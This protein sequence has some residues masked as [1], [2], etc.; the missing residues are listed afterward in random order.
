MDAAAQSSGHDIV[1]IRASARIESEHDYQMGLARWGKKCEDAVEESTNDYIFSMIVIVACEHE[2]TVIV[3]RLQRIPF[4]NEPGRKLFCYDSLC[5]EPVDWSAI[6]RLKRSIYGG[7]KVSMRLTNAGEENEDTL[8][9]LKNVYLAFATQRASDNLCEDITAC[10]VPGRQGDNPTNEVLNTAWKSLK[11]L[12][13]RHV[14]PKIGNIRVSQEDMLHHMYT[15]GHWNPSPEHHVL[16]TYQANPSDNSGRKRMRHL[17]DNTRCGDTFFNEWPVPMYQPSQMPRVS[18]DE[19][20]KMFAAETAVD[21]GAE[22]GAGTAMIQDLGD[23]VIP[24][25]RETHV[26]FMQEMI[27]VFGIEAAVLFWVGS[28]QSLLA[29][30]LE[31]KRA[32]AVVRNGHEKKFV[33]A[34]LV[35]AVKTLGLAPDRRPAKP[36]ELV[37]WETRRAVGGA[38]PKAGATPTPPR[39]PA[40]AA[41]GAPSVFTVP[42]PAAA[43]SSA[44]AAS[45]SPAPAAT[46]APP[47][48]LAAFGASSLR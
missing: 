9:V 37:A 26:K 16:F 38:L 27:H 32:V 2:S 44:P 45:S 14:G 10:I 36:A 41:G 29:F 39:P 24:F 13:N 18:M 40:P 34:N 33:K 4:M 1:E 28:G 12:G 47:A 22:D 42:A 11:A 20:E 5:R 31:R 6:K 25:P 17:K 46:P 3:N 30:V 23:N 21:D 15:R 43:Q 7:A 19:H 35:R 48:A 8:A